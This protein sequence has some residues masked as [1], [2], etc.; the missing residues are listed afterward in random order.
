MRT[1]R[2]ERRFDA[3]FV[4]DAVTYMT[5]E[6]DL[7]AAI[8][9]AFIHCEPGGVA[10]F[11][12]DH[13]RETF[14]PSTSHEGHDGPDGRALRF[15]EW[16]TDPDP[17]D[18]QYTVDY[19]ILLREPNG[20][21]RVEHERHIEGLFSRADWLMWLASAGFQPTVLAVDHSEL[22]EGEYEIF[23]AQKPL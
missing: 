3:V 6:R 18:T 8:E 17:N 13:V 10:I 19:A 22:D 1:V 15:L 7:R 9:T 23:V 21:V 11:A 5:T 4:H 12:P 20:V 14:H 2:L 16:T